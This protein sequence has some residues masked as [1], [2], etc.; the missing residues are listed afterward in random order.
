MWTRCC[1]LLVVAGLCVLPGCGGDDGPGAGGELRI[2]ATDPSEDETKVTATETV[3]AGVV[4]IELHNRGDM[5]H[6]AQLFRIDGNHTAEE[7]VSEWIENIDGAT[8]PKWLHLAGGVAPIGPGERRSVTQ[9][10]APGRY[11]VADLQEREK[12]PGAK[13]TNAAKGGTAVFEVTGDGGGELPP[14]EGSITATDK[15]FDAEGLRAGKQELTFVNAGREPHHATL[16]L[17]P[18][19]QTFEQAARELFGRKGSSG[20]PPMDVPANHATAVLEGGDSQVTTMRLEPGRYLVACF[21]ADRAGGPPHL[22][23]TISSLVVR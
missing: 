13:L 21:A 10:L 16:F 20:W 19:G 8:H 4:E 2:S 22:S 18:K 5:H 14:T 3:A 23:E 17:V 9:V 7:L 15:R 6:D 12:G 1:V 11:V